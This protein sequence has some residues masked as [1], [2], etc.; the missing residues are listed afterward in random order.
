MA[1]RR[2]IKRDAVA[3][4]QADRAATRERRT[5]LKA[6]T[7]EERK[8]AKAQDARD[9][10]EAKASAKAERKAARAGM[11]RKERREDS[12]RA[13]ITRKVAH[14][15]R[16]AIGW[17]VA[18]VAVVGIGALAAPYVGG[19]ARV[20][21]LE[22]ADGTVEA[23]QAREDA[24]VVAENVSD[25]GMVLLKNEGDVLPLAG[26][27]VNVFS[28]ASF[29]L[30]LG[31]G[32]S[33][34]STVAGAPTLYEALEAQ[35]VAYNEDLYATMEDAGAAHSEGAS[36]A[37]VQM[38]QLAMG[39]GSSEPAPD[40][41]TDDV[42]A[43]AADYSDT[44]IVV[45]GVSGGE[46]TDLTQEQLQLSDE[47]VALL[48]AVTAHQDDVIV[49]INAGNQM[50]LGF[51]DDY[52]QIKAAVWMGTPGPQGA[53]SL[54]KILTGEVNPSGRL[55][56]TYAYDVT[57]APATEN[58]GSHRY[59]NT[60]RAFLDYEEGIYVGYRYYETRYEGDEAGYEAAVQFPFGYGLSYTDF[61]W[62]ASE[63]VIADGEVT[64]DVS[65]TNV[66][67]AAGK[68]VVQV[69]FSAPYLDG[70]VEKSSIELAGYAKTDLLAPGDEETVTVSFGVQDMASWDTGQGAYVLDAGA[71]EI[72]A[73]TD[74]HT[75]IASFTHDVG[76][77]VVYT[78][79]ADTG[80]DYARLFEFAEG[81]LEFLSRA[82]WE[83]TYPAGPD[84]T[85]TASDEALALMDPELVPADGDAPTYGADNGLTL[86]DMVGLDYDDP[87]WDAFLDQLTV[88]EQI[89]LFS[90]G[91]YKTYEVDRLGIPSMVMLDSPAG[92]NS[93]FASLEAAAYPSEIVIASTWNDALAYEVGAAIGHEADLY[94]VD[95]WYAPGMNLHRTA[96]GGRDF[97]YFSEDPLISGMMAAGMVSGAQDQGVL[98]TIKHFVLNDQEVNARSGINVSLSEQALREL[99][100]QP[101]EVAVKESAP[102]G[103]MSSFINLGGKWAGGSDELLQEVLRG[104]WGFEGFVTTDA[105]LGGWM[106]PVQAALHGNDLMLAVFPSATVASMSEA[107]EEDPVGLGHALR[108]RVH[109][110]LYSVALTDRVS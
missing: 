82:D 102:T 91:A 56:D 42:M 23:L 86:A 53:V 19:L 74:V 35:G 6:M 13:R 89:H 59:T 29:N 44:A 24:L 90:Y 108:D 9:A 15:R 41:L 22:F 20:A 94:G 7:P 85:E 54:A 73:S 18:G 101:F 46:G 95:V 60:N 104:E 96:M 87:Q 8:A 100:L 84:G 65:V 103:A 10:R 76:E 51:L 5:Q 11:N 50:E 66:G 43:Q 64:V 38:A 69:Y 27:R 31:G 79:D 16:R 78:A 58:L 63:P 75:P 110:V 1:T 83:G 30:L 55:T 107:I 80:Y 48:D 57:S 62:A 81:D 14:R 105:V 72:S 49:V 97:E 67:D 2:E 34:G 88:E 32:G 93:L 98:T 36:N 37:F 39:G 45:F 4:V 28:F 40:Y 99:Y 3:R 92:L 52:P 26:D 77:S 71:Y 12:R 68:D 109:A 33:G 106:D 70:G 21:S 25:E 47:Q 61:E 17:G